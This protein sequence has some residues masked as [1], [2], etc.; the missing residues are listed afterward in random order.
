MAIPIKPFMRM[1]D[2]LA[3][4]SRELASG[5]SR[6]LES[7]LDAL[8]EAQGWPWNASR[9]QLDEW[10]DLYSRIDSATVTGPDR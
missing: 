2:L 6:Q 10:D 8:Q 7:E 5:G 9:E 4:D 1:T 3:Q